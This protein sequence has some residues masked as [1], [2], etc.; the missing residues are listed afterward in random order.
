MLVH[1]P[2]QGVQN[3]AADI[4]N[5]VMYMIVQ[6]IEIVAL[7]DKYAATVIKKCACKKWTDKRDQENDVPSSNWHMWSE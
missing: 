1:V 6:R 4:E 7:Q 5:S 2:R 3:A